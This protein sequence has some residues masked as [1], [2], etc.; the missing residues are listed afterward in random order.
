VLMEGEYGLNGV[1]FGVPVKLG[2]GGVEQ[3]IEL[4]LTDEEQAGVK[5][6]AALVQDSINALPAEYR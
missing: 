3:I 6:S 5:R 1:F 4:P 2:A